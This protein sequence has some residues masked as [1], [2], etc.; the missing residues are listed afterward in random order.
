M[1]LKEKLKILTIDN[2]ITLIIG[3]IM[4]CGSALALNYN[5]IS[6]FKTGWFILFFLGFILFMYN[7]IILIGIK[8]IGYNIKRD[9]KDL[10]DGKIDGKQNGNPLE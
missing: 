5:F 1:K 7:L 2:I 9:L 6:S 4:Y 3:F 10:S 8:N